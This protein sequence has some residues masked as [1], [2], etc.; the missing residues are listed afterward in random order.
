MAC[1]FYFFLV[2]AILDE[3]GPLISKLQK[4]ID[5]AVT[6][7]KQDCRNLVQLAYYGR[8]YNQEEFAEVEEEAI[9]S[10]GY[11]VDSLEAA[12]WSLITTDSFEECALKAVNLGGD[13]DSIGAI[14]CGLAGL[15][16]GYNQIPEEWKM[17][18]QKREWIEEQ[19]CRTE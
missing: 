13:T 19:C 9:N 4:G 10:S 18:M 1:G 14:A 17:V 12:V 6:F 5:A 15:H 11:V 8:L 7:Y 2:K 3:A 16:Y